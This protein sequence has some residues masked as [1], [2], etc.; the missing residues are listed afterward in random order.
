[1]RSSTS[2]RC[3]VKKLFPNYFAKTRLGLTDFGDEAVIID[4]SCRARCNQA[5]LDKFRWI[6]GTP[7]DFT[8]FAPGQPDSGCCF[9]FFSCFNTEQDCIVIRSDGSWRDEDCGLSRPSICIVDDDSGEPVVVDNVT[10]PPVDDLFP[11]GSADYTGEIVLIVFV[12]FLSAGTLGGI[13]FLG[14]VRR[15][16]LYPDKRGSYSEN[17]KYTPESS[18]RALALDGNNLELHQSDFSKESLPWKSRARDSA[19]L[20][21]FSAFL[22]G[23]QDRH[24][25]ST[26]RTDRTSALSFGGAIMKKY[27]RKRDT[28]DSE[29]L[30]RMRREEED[31]RREDD[32]DSSF[33][34]GSYPVV[35]KIRL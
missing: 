26:T 9:V 10:L 2:N 1:M 32:D 5:C 21:R 30:A 14:Y 12:A 16:A 35:S 20:S 23:R 3:N 28:T 15:H 6:D 17:P 34:A 18:G 29:R 24:S 13:C 8:N 33:E 25:T 7:N 27:F 22:R 19:A 31:A 11:E 4:G